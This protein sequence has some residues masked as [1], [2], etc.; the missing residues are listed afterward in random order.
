MLERAPKKPPR[1]GPPPPGA[2]GYDPKRTR[3]RRILKKLTLKNARLRLRNRLAVSRAMKELAKFPKNANAP[4]HSL[5]AP[6]IVSLT[7]FPARFATLHLTI[8]SLIDQKVRPDRILLWIA[9]ED[10]AKLP[11]EVR[12]LEGDLFS[13][14]ACEDLRNFKKILPTLKEHPGAFVVICDDDTY[15]ADDWLKRLIDAYDPAQPSLVCHRAHRLKHT[16]DGQIAPYRTW[17]RDVSGPSTETPRMDLLPTGNGGVLY[18]PGSLPPMTSDFDLIRKLSSTSDDVWLFFMAKQAGYAVRRV[19]G[20]KQRFLE[21]PKTQ[22]QALF[23]FH[24][25]GTKDEHIH[26]MA[27]HFGVP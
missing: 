22:E 16:P 19:P 11:Q 15:Y 9:H 8:M 26:D 6:L 1:K 13:V 7:S 10:L 27:R 18:P 12:S 20:P 4:R 17:T 5:P 14:R 24:R 2:F 3:A 23:A 21:W 25:G